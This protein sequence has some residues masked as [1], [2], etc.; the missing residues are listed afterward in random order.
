MPLFHFSGLFLF[1]GVPILLLIAYYIKTKNRERIQMI[2]KGINPD[3]GLNVSQYR[4][5]SSLRNGILFLFF[6]L[7]LLMGQLLVVF[8][9]FDKPLSHLIMLLI[10]GGIGF[11]INFL[12][13]QKMHR[14]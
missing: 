10:F 4:E 3:E 1:I 6:G 2:E 8:D 9:A 11:L 12:I 13:I 7:G 5:H 14:K